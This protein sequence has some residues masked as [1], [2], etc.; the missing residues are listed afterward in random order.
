MSYEKDYY[1]ILQVNR[2]ASQE[3]IER[4]YQRLSQTY[5]PETSQKR[6]AAQR[7]ADVQEAY[8]TLKDPRKRRQYEREVAAARAAAGGMLPADVLSRRFVM[9]SGGVIV[10]SIGV[11]LALVLILGG[12][13]S[14]EEVVNLT[15]TPTVTPFGQTPAPTPPASPPEITAEF[16]TT[17]SGL[18]IAA[19]QEGT[20]ATPQDG[21]VAKVNY[22]GWLQDGGTLFD[23]SLN[24]GRQPFTFTVG[25][26]G[27]IKAWDEAVK[28]MKVGG[29]YR[30]IAP[31]DIAYGATG[32]PPVIPANATLIFDISVLE[33]APP[34]P[35]GQTPSPAPTP[36]AAA[37]PEP[38]VLDTAT[39]EATPTPEAS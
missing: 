25:T 18:Q 22:S 5:N 34:T 37:T 11:I 31:P 23:S 24:P 32:S 8:E 21:D 3:E 1:A 28:L 14:G 10:A 30:I 20:G 29:V 27:V 2:N 17:E 9:L 38:T 39:P 7:Y 6:R 36:T 35:V 4:A 12:G 15:G 33:A 26:G 13:G 19:I 16:T